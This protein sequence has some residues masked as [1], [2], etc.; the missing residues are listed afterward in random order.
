MLW[1]VAAVTRRPAS[2]VRAILTLIA[3]GL[4]LPFIVTRPSTEPRGTP[5]RGRRPESVIVAPIDA[6][7]EVTVGGARLILK[8]GA[9]IRVGGTRNVGRAA[10]PGGGGRL[11]DDP[12]EIGSSGY[13]GVGCYARTGRN[14]GGG[15]GDE[16]G[17]GEGLSL[18]EL[19]EIFLQQG[20]LTVIM[21]GGSP[22][23]LVRVSTYHGE[24]SASHAAF[25]ID[26]QRLDTLISVQS[27][28]VTVSGY[29]GAPLVVNAGAMARLDGLNPTWLLPPDT[30]PLARPSPPPVP[31]E[32]HYPAS[33]VGSDRVADP[34]ERREPE[35]ASPAENVN[36]APQSPAQRGISPEQPD[37]RQVAPIAV[38]PIV[39]Q[40]RSYP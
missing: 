39:V 3:I 7:R 22:R 5:A 14:R 31:L 40:P 18:G 1:R 15:D 20:G 38:D 26:L 25:E 13:Q 19:L 16:G 32:A 23:D 29:T 2:L 8:K 17:S 11:P 34:I 36:P 37:P 35:P 30:T 10:T 24:V 28:F 12:E 4:L 27:G 9:R 21:E 33:G 6:P